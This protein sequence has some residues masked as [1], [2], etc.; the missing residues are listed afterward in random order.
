MI[1]L[2]VSRTGSGQV[3]HLPQSTLVT[4]RISSRLRQ[5]VSILN[6]RVGRISRY[7]PR[8]CLVKS[9]QGHVL[10]LPWLALVA[11]VEFEWYKVCMCQRD[12]DQ[13]EE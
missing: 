5:G 11:L 10:P 7:G 12:Q 6:L 8:P 1:S 3:I 2:D 4:L 13:A 9:C